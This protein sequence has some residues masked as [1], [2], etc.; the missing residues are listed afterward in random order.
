MPAGTPA[1]AARRIFDSY[2]DAKPSRLLLTKLD[3]AESLSPLVSLLH[4][5]QRVLVGGAVGACRLPA[6]LG[7]Q[8]GVAQAVLRGDLGGR[9]AR[10]AVA[11]PARN[12]TLHC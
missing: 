12:R 2:A 5:W 10:D 9:V 7:L 1:S 4:Q 6:V 8:R 11:D 3:E